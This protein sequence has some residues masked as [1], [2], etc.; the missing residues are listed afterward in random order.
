MIVVVNK[1]VSNQNDNIISAISESK[2]PVVGSFETTNQFMSNFQDCSLMQ[3]GQKG[4]ILIRDQ[5]EVGGNQQ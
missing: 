1:P 5:I 2:F 4:N 3:S